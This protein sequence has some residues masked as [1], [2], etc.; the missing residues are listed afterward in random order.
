[1]DDKKKE[2]IQD[3]IEQLK[4]LQEPFKI[5]L[6]SFLAVFASLLT[7]YSAFF[8]LLLDNVINDEIKKNWYHSISYEPILFF[9]VACFIMILIVLIISMKMGSYDKKIKKNYKL[10]LSRRKKSIKS[11]LF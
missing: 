1:M 7:I 3:R 6:S 9:F 2:L 8:F 4:Y 5:V 10:L 11:S